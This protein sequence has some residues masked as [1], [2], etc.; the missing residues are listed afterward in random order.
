M[1]YDIPSPQYYGGAGVVPHVREELIGHSRPPGCRATAYG[2]G[3]RPERAIVALKRP[4][5]SGLLWY[6]CPPKQKEGF[7]PNCLPYEYKASQDDRIAQWKEA[8]EIAQQERAIKLFVDF[9]EPQNS[10]GPYLK[11]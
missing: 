8:H 5:Y 9:R 11:P 2:P 3:P 1:T 7:Q 6:A 4:Q 10:P